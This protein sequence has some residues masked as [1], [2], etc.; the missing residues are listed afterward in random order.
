[1]VGLEHNGIKALGVGL[2]GYSGSLGSWA[3]GAL[4]LTSTKAHGLMGS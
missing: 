2:F 1:V 3:P 4:G